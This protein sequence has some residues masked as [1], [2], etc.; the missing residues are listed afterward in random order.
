[1]KDLN[2]SCNPSTKPGQLQDTAS[3]SA[4]EFAPPQLARLPAALQQS[5]A[6][7][8]TQLDPQSESSRRASPI[9]AADHGGLRT[10]FPDGEPYDV[11]TGKAQEHARGHP[12]CARWRWYAARAPQLQ[13]PCFGDRGGDHDHHY[14]CRQRVLA[15]A[16]SMFYISGRDD[17]ARYPL[18]SARSTLH[19]QC[20][21]ATSC[22]PVSPVL[23]SADSRSNLRSCPCVPRSLR[24]NPMSGNSDATQPATSCRNIVHAI[25]PRVG[26]QV[27]RSIFGN[28]FGV[29][30]TASPT[31]AKRRGG[32]CKMQR[33][34]SRMP[35]T[36][37]EGFT[38]AGLHELRRHLI[39]TEAP[40][41]YSHA[42]VGGSQNSVFV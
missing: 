9:D 33:S 41:C 18:R 3:P 21:R 20:N 5:S 30:W 25:T 23:T 13:L 19:P 15:V 40:R 31:A 16:P 22:S 12:E 17:R 42:Q 4:V 36:E 1:M 24:A 29:R 7:A 27:R 6:N 35:P 26:T 10:R 11:D 8:D 28:R 32:R 39:P 2:E 38:R 14:V 37:V 34:V